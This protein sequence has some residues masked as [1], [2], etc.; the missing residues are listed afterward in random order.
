MVQWK[1]MFDMVK[2]IKVAYGKKM[3]EIKNNKRNMAPTVDMSFNMKSIFFK[4][5]PTGQTWCA[6]FHRWHAHH[7]ECV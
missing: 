1:Y 3:K 2:S 6:P 7:E 4:Y 5:L